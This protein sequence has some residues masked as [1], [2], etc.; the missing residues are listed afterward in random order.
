MHIVIT[1]IA[2]LIAVSIVM[3][4]LAKAGRRTQNAG[5]DFMLCYPRALVIFCFFKVVSLRLRAHVWVGNS[6]C[7]P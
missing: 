2:I 5:D 6:L 3:G 1:N 4:A 7:L